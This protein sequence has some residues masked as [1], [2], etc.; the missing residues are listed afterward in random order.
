VLEGAGD[1]IWD[2]TRSLFW[3][4]YG[5]RS[6]AAARGKVADVFGVEVMPIELATPRFYHLDTAMCVLSRG[7]IIYFPNAFTHASK[8]A[9]EARVAQHARIAVSDDDARQFAANAVCI[10]NTLLLSGCSDRL[11]TQLHE[12]GYRVVATPLSS[13]LRSGGAAFCLTLRLDWRSRD[14]DARADDAAAA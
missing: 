4:G 11:R 7:E 5:Q 3:T 12:R 6:D 1:C 13:F 14:V 9:F 10:D 8:D 2:R